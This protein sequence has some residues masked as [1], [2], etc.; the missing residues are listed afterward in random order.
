MLKVYSYYLNRK[1][2]N[3][4]TL[5]LNV[6]IK[7]PFVKTPNILHEYPVFQ[8]KHFKRNYTRVRER[9]ET[10]S[11]SWGG[12]LLSL[13]SSYFYLFTD[14]NLLK[15]AKY[16]APRNKNLTSWGINNAKIH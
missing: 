8:N 6:R 11:L 16:F 7:I 14:K 5:P 10:G 4:K 9:S 12:A 15:Q 13:Y 1:S 2:Y 3:K